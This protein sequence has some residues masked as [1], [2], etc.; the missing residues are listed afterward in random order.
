MQF[1]WMLK[2]C[3]HFRFIISDLQHGFLISKSCCKFPIEKQHVSHFSETCCKKSKHFTVRIW[4]FS[5]CAVNGWE[6]IQHE[7]AF[8]NPML[9]LAFKK[10][11][12]NHNFRFCAVLGRGKVQQKYGYGGNVL[13]WSLRKYSTDMDMADL[14]CKRPS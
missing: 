3:L 5:I 4:V 1:C 2:N 9:Y 12:T 6:E 11:S 7:S 13:Y 10:Y 14:C 8:Q